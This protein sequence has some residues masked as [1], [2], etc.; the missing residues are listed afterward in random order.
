MDAKL[1]LEFRLLQLRTVLDT[2]FA[3]HTRTHTNF[4]HSIL[5]CINPSWVLTM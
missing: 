2:F 3:S 1:I 5:F 4:K